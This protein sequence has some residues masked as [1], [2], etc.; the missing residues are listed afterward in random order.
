MG[1]RLSVLLAAFLVA[2]SAAR[3]IG[4]S[5]QKPLAF[6]VASV[7]SNTSGDRRASLQMNLPDSFAATNQTLQSLVS[8][9]YQVPI[10]KITGAP[11]W[12][13]TDRFDIAGKADHRLTFDEKRE[14]MRTLLEDRFKLKTHRETH[15][16]RMYALAFARGDHQL[17]PGIKP[18]RY[19]CAAIRAARQRGESASIPSPAPGDPPPCGAFLGLQY[20]ARG[21]EMASFAT[22]LSAMMRETVVDDT[23]L[24]GWWDFDVALNFTGFAGPPVGAV[25]PTSDT[26]SIFTSL[27]EQ[28]GLKLDTRHGPVETF[29]I[30]HIERPTPD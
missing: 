18:S 7:K 21:V 8:L 13:A 17:G 3:L 29:V 12:F 23:G 20:R 1:R 11:G 22:T 5:D 2:T 6:E 30:D 10:F 26:P 16:G 19:D 9:M 4:Q 24:Q 14:M 25:S 28:L 15:E 27:Q